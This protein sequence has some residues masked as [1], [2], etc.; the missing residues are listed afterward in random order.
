M[1]IISMARNMKRCTNKMKRYRCYRDAVSMRWGV[2]GYANRK[3]VG[4]CLENK[5]RVEFPDGQFTG[6]KVFEHDERAVD[7]KTSEED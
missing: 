4:W 7:L 6:F 1:Q 3:R 2:M 5:L